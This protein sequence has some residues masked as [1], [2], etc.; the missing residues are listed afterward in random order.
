MRSLQDHSFAEYL[1]RIN[2]FFNFSKTLILN[3][4]KSYYRK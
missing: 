3:P 4:I 1:M 2:Q